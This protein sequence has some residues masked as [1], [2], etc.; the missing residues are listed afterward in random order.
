M[1]PEDL[2][3]HYAQVHDGSERG[4]APLQLHA[5]GL[6]WTD[7]RALHGGVRE[8]RARGL[9]RPPSKRYQWTGV[10]R[11][12]G[13]PARRQ[14]TNFE[15]RKSESMFPDGLDPIMMARV[16]PLFVRGEYETAVFKAFK[17]TPF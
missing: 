13:G 10:L 8:A 4:N 6:S 17:T 9:Y 12:H 7:R 2:G 11:H 15:A 1:Q 3:T 16:K 5:D 14:G